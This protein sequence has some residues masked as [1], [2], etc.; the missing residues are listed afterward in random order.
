MVS[1]RRGMVCWS[2]DSAAL[3]DELPYL[4]STP[5]AGYLKASIRFV[6]RLPRELNLG[7]PCCQ[8]E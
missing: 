4:E 7:D 8:G 5:T 3:C 2:N 1:E 6:K